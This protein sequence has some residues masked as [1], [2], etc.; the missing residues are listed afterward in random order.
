MA[1]LATLAFMITN[2]VWSPQYSI[3]LVPLLVLALPRWRLV[4]GWAALETVYWY[5]RMW[6]FLPANQA[7]PHWL[8][9]TV[10]IVRLGLLVFMAV[11][12]IRQ[13]MGRSPDPIREAHGG[14][15]PLAGVLAEEPAEV[16]D[17]AP[18]NQSAREN[19]NGSGGEV[20]V[21]KKDAEKKESN[22]G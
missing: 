21:N 5:L 9:D 10:T 22:D 2:K 1:F 16:Q 6:Q 18:T 12:V 7:A 15:D 4:F 20:G 11:L 19:W 17:G 13:I 3:W 14:C 8:V